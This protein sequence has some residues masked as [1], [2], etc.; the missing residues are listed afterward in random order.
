MARPPEAEERKRA[1]GDKKSKLCG[2]CAKQ[3]LAEVGQSAEEM[4]ES[5]DYFV[6]RA[7]W[8]RYRKHKELKTETDSARYLALQKLLHDKRTHPLFITLIEELLEPYLPPE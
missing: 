7:V 2:S 3:F 6:F 1:R 4:G 8:E 5:T